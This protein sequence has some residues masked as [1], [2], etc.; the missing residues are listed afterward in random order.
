[1]SLPLASTPLELTHHESIGSLSLTLR[2]NGVAVAKGKAG[3]RAANAAEEKAG[4]R[5]ADAVEEKAASRAVDAG[6]EKSDLRLLSL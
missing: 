3:L 2:I 5:E 1:M 4:S 6:E